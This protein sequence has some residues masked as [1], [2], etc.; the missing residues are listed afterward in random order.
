MTIE[1][2]H[3]SNF[4]REKLNIHAEIVDLRSIKPIDWE[5]IIISLKKT[6]ILLV[7]D[8]G[9]TTGSVAGEVIANL[10]I[11]HFHLFKHPPIRLAMP[12]VPEPTSFALT[13]NFYIKAKDIAANVSQCLLN[14]A[15]VVEQEFENPKLHDIPGD[16]FKGPF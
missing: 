15:V 13:K 7:V 4:L 14:N 5:T 6:G 3:A 9:F 10:T 1:A 11:N 16:W 12:D 2:I 8:S